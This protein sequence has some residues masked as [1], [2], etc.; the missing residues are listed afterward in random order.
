M[1]LKISSLRAITHP[2]LLL[3]TTTG[4]PM[5]RGLNTCSQEA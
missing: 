1:D 4:L 2:S 3:N 5:S